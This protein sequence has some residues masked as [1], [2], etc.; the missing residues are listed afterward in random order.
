MEYYYVY[1]HWLT[2]KRVAQVCQHQLIFLYYFT[3]N[4]KRLRVV[5]PA[6]RSKHGNSYSN[7]SGWVAG[8]LS[9][10]L[11]YCIKTA[12][13]IWKPFG[14]SESHIILVSWDPL[15]IHNSKG[16]HSSG[17][18]NTRGVGGKICDFCAIFDRYRRLSR[19]RCEI[20]RWLL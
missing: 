12:K 4:A 16:N 7:V 20:V 19:K 6:R 17:T 9:V 1:W 3:W 8:W 18:L 13:P 5:L 11:W 2:Y 10:T 14:P 15:P